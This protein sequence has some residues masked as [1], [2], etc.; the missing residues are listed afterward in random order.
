ML[1]Q[2]TYYLILDFLFHLYNGS[3]IC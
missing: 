1:P 2:T 3:Y